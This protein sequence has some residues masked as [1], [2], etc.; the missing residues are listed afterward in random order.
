MDEGCVF[1]GDCDDEEEDGNEVK[2]EEGIG[3][4]FCFVFVY[5]LIYLF[6]CGYF[7]DM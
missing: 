4:K 2:D 5:I 6:F 1:K 7:L 3:V